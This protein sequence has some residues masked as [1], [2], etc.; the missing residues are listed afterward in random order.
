M[1]IH[2]RKKEKRNNHQNKENQTMTKGKK[3][4]WADIPDQDFDDAKAI[5]DALGIRRSTL[6]LAALQCLAY[7]EY[8][9]SQTLL[10]SPH[11]T[12]GLPKEEA[13]RLKGKAAVSQKIWNNFFS[14]WVDNYKRGGEVHTAE[15]DA[16]PEPEVEE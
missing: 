4:F 1:R 7:Q 13:R 8:T 12:E 9:R 6:L 5:C 3:R 15:V 2:G 11:L 14:D 16:A 10:K